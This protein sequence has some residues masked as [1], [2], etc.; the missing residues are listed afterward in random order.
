MRYTPRTE[1]DSRISRLQALLAASEI[2]CALIRH[3]TNLYYFS[4]TIQNSHLF[5][6]AVGQPVLMTRRDF[7]RARIESQLERVIPLRSLRQMPDLLKD[8]GI[9]RLGTLG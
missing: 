3:N 2:D 7:T 6:P 4:G 8:H 5:I 1:L 9:Q